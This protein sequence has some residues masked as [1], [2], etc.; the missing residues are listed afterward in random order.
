MKVQ[1]F[2]HET[3]AERKCYTK[4]ADCPVLSVGESLKGRNRKILIRIL[5]IKVEQKD[6]CGTV[7]VLSLLTHVKMWLK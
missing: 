6:F 5:K 2:W 1:R 3:K 7:S 4:S